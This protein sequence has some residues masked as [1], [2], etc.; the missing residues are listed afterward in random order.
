MAELPP[1]RYRLRVRYGECDGQGVV[2]N[3]RYGEY[4]DLAV[5]EFLRAAFAPQNVFDGS[6]EFQVVRQLVEWTGPARFDDVLDISVRLKTLGTTSYTLALDMRKAGA[7]ETIVT[8]ETVNVFVDGR[9][10]TKKALTEAMRA[11][12]TAAARG[13]VVDHAGA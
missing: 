10:W 8:A 6:F 11:R 3:P 5:T 4:V 12:L 9:T 13:Q 1:F 2:Y 7:A